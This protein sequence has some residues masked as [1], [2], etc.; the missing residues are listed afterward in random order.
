LVAGSLIPASWLIQAQRV[1]KM[2]HAEALQLFDRFDVLLAAAAP[3]YAPLIGA[4]T[5]TINGR[6][7][8]TRATL[9]V[10][11]QPISC[12][13][14]PACAAP[15]WPEPEGINLPVGVQL[16]AAPW[17]EDL[18]LAA[19]AVLERAGVSRVRG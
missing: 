18:C 3:D 7:V 19:A 1:R 5:F 4:E 8:P 15:L 6:T 17:R 9:G 12:I 13:G 11:T 16:I 14:L 10:L 2:A